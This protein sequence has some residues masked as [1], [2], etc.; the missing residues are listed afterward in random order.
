MACVSV[1]VYVC[2]RAATTGKEEEGATL[3]FQVLFLGRHHFMSGG[4]ADSPGH[5]RSR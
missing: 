4:F 1:A 2:E 3:T 5:I